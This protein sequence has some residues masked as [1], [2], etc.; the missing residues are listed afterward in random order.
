MIEEK[1][2]DRERKREFGTESE[3]V[4]ERAKEWES[5]KKCVFV[6]VKEK[7]W[8]MRYVHCEKLV[9][10]G[11]KD[12]SLL[13]EVPLRSKKVGRWLYIRFHV[14]IRLMNLYYHFTKF[15]NSYSPMYANTTFLGLTMFLYSLFDI[16][17]ID[18]ILY[19]R[20]HD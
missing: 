2:R 4:R 9:T 16:E 7:K 1:R 8:K 14:S 3:Q 18:Y 6:C 19:S 11:Q 20:R 15:I 17:P 10:S 13:S 5:A 12:F